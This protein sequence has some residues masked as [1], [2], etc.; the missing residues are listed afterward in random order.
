VSAR[1]RPAWGG[2][3][4]QGR[5][6]GGESNSLN[7]RGGGTQTSKAVKKRHVFVGNG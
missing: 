2:E 4:I 6:V 3:K 5:C 1:K 7:L